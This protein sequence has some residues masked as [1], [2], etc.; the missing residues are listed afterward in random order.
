MPDRTKDLGRESRASRCKELSHRQAGML[1]FAPYWAACI[2][3]TSGARLRDHLTPGL[4]DG[5]EYSARTGLLL[6]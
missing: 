3:I 6:P 4:L 1:S 2:T 5:W